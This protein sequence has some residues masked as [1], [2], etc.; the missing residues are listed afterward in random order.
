MTRGKNHV[1]CRLYGLWEKN[2]AK[3]VGECFSCVLRNRRQCRGRTEFSWFPSCINLQV[4]SRC[5]MMLLLSVGMISGH[6]FNYSEDFPDESSNFWCVTVYNLRQMDFAGTILFISLLFSSLALEQ[7]TP[8]RIGLI[9][10]VCFCPMVSCFSACSRNAGKG[11]TSRCS[12]VLCEPPWVTSSHHCRSSIWS[13]P[14]TGLTR[15]LCLLSLGRL[16]M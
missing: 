15:L 16:N 3:L 11:Q 13:F 4:S 14:R 12:G 2:H 5:S 10:H 8:W 7:S 9:L 1:L 6:L